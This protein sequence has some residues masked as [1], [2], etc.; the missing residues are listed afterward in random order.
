MKY[1]LIGNNDI[2]NI[3]QTILKNRGIKDID[4][5]LNLNDSVLYNYEL[6]QN[7]NKSV[8]LLKDCIEK[9]KYIYILIDADCDGY[10]SGSII[11]HYIKTQLEY[12]NMEYFL[13]T[14]KQHGLSSEIMNILKDKKQGL[15]IIPDAGTNDTEQ[16]KILSECGFEIL[17]LDHHLKE[18]DNPYAVIV[19]NQI[20]DYPNKNLCGAGV[21]YKFLQALDDN[22]WLDGADEYLDLVALANIADVMDLRECETKYLVDKGLS[23][24]KHPLFIAL[25]N[26]QSYSVNNTEKP[27]IIDVSFYIAPLINAMIRIGEQEEKELMFKA[28][29]M[30]YDE[31][32]YTPRK[33]KNNPNPETI[34][35]SIYD[36]VARLCC[37][38]KSRQS[39]MQDKAVQEVDNIYSEE[40]KNNSI[41]FINVSKIESVTKELTGLVAMKIASKYDKPCLVIRKDNVKSNDNNII[42]SGS[43]RNVN[44]GFIEDLKAELEE[45]GLFEELVGHANAFGVSIKRENIPLAIEYFNKK[46]SDIDKSKVYAVDFIFEENIDYQIIKDIHSIQH[47]F[48][49]FLK[50]PLVVIKNVDVDLLGFEEFG[51]GKKHWK[52]QNELIE[53]IKFNVPEDDEMLNINSFEYGNVVIDV[54]G[55]TNINTYGGKTIPQIIVE[56]YTVV[57]KY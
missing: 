1:K 8:E 30:E 42:F 55:K 15:I 17:I 57:E 49:G 4:K 16:C 9:N 28:F 56:D 54:V 50:E 29:I 14:E 31:F 10:I 37:N 34:M 26:K 43:A 20:C 19:N 22:Y 44:D 2:S 48:S 33:S 5:Y 24:I 46:Y 25:L 23:N 38:T 7:I 32:K 21:A 53:Y 40:N 39:K 27:T 52:F 18:N 3:K 36:R 35:E 13:H 51:D 11:Y 6:L 45:S 12:N 41:C 47:L